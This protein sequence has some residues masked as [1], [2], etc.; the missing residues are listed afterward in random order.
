MYTERT[1]M[2]ASSPLEA[3]DKPRG[4]GAWR[5]KRKDD[6]S[7]SQ[8]VRQSVSQGRQSVSQSGRQAGSQSGRQASND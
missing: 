8:S 6:Q 3:H 5:G 7:V 4:E 1:R 2:N